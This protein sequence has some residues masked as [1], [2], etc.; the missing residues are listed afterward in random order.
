M[1]G[2]IKRIVRVLVVLD[3]LVLAIYFGIHTL[4]PSI[5][6]FIHPLRYIKSDSETLSIPIFYFDG[7]EAA[8]KTIEL[9]RGTAVE[10]REENDQDSLVSYDGETFS[11][12]N[13]YLAT[14]LKECVETEYVYPRKLITLYDQKHGDLSSTVAEK[15]EQLKVTKVDEN[16]LDLST[17][18]VK[19]YEVTK[20]NQTYWVPGTYVE[21][22]KEK[23]EVNYGSHIQY[24]TYWDEYYGDGYSTDA[25]IDQID[26]K[27]IEKEEYEGNPIPKTVKAYHVSLSNFINHK[28]EL[29]KL[30]KE[31]GINAFVVEIKDD[32][33]IVY[34]DSQTVKDFLNDPEK[35]LY[36][37]LDNDELADVFKEYEEAGYYLV[38]RIVTFKDPV[39]ASQNPDESY[40]DPKG[41]LIDHDGYYWPSPYSR[42]VWMYNVKIAEEIAPYVNE[43]QFDYVRFPDGTLQNTL[44]KTG[45][46][47]NEYDESKTAAIQ[48]FLQYARDIL[49]E[50]KTYISA[51][52]FAWPIVVKDDQDIGQFLPAVANVVD[53]VSPMPYLDHFSLGA[54]DIEDPTQAP[55]ETLEKF[56]TITKTQLASI[57]YPAI[58]RPWI[59]GY[60][61]T[62]KDMEAQIDG[63]EKIGYHDYL[64]W[65]GAGNIEDIEAR[66]SGLK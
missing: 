39:Y 48:G 30:N 6:S 36:P 42:T 61:N 43:I 4:I 34:F 5:N 15:G 33:G 46:F 3:C 1:S 19:W 58:Y 29:L 50:E 56:S 35:A 52:L 8:T 47:K 55:E 16:D 13:E 22:T 28:N 62:S 51:D 21:T 7:D 41:N 40:T 32:S 27:P 9:K 10:L 23:A 20:D 66:L 24:L 2:R 12:S 60:S 38:A 53:V 64:V 63:I 11:I 59:Q 14:S 18:I 44:D 65:S 57:E 54:M 49:S 26:Y 37:I 45:D 17:G 25:Y 31:S